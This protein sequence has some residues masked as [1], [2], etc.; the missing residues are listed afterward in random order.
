MLEQACLL[1]IMVTEKNKTTTK[2][3]TLEN[4]LKEKTFKHDF[5]GLAYQGRDCVVKQGGSHHRPGSN[6]V[7]YLYPV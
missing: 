5:R 7:G 2:K 6:V 4:N 3:K 1:Y